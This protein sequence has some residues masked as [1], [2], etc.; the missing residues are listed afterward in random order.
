VAE[1][2]RTSVR[3]EGK[4]ATMFEVPLDIRALYGRAR[5]PVRVTINGHTYRS[6]IAV[7]GE[8]NYLPLNRHNR[9][10]AGVE[11][12]DEIE[13]S[14]ELDDEPREVD[15][16]RDL[17]EALQDDPEAQRAFTGMSYSHQREY[18][19][20][21]AEAKRSE[22]RARRIQRSMK[23]LREGRTQR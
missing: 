8:R 10:A 15:L 17:A 6:T 2:F 22:T 21:I 11:A 12:G 5:P 4:T 23:K 9:A 13:V 19:D 3:L 16:P 14:L 20:H 1:R 7:Y 18:V